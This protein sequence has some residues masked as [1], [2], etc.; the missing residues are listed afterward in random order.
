MS[1]YRNDCYAMPMSRPAVPQ[2]NISSMAPHRPLKMVWWLRSDGWR[3]MA[4]RQYH[5]VLFAGR[6]AFA[7]GK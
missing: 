5:R 1:Q 7:S 4:S 6:Q 3:M 2:E